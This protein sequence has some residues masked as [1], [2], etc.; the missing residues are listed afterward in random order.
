MDQEQWQC[1]KCGK[2]GGFILLGKGMV[3]CSGCGA[4]HFVMMTGQLHLAR[5]TGVLDVQ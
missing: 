5:Y 3:K 2:V 4:I 1:H